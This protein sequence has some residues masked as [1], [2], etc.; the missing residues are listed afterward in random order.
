[1][2]EKHCPLYKEPC[3]EHQCRWYIQL[4]GT[5]PQDGRAISEWGCAVEWLPIL[6]IEQAKE[7]RQGAAAVESLRNENVSNAKQISAGF[8]ALANGVSRALPEKVV[9]EQG[10]G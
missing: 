1:M 5:H 9:S 4:Q 8:L 10:R 2:A 7:I 3:H 6:M